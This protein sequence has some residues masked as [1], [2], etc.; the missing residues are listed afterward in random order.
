MAALRDA[1]LG[2]DEQLTAGGFGERDDGV[3]M[4]VCATSQS[5]A[6]RAD[7][8]RSVLA[9]RNSANP[10][11][12]S[13]SPAATCTTGATA[14][15]T[16]Y[17]SERSPPARPCAFVA[18]RSRAWLF[19]GRQ[20]GAKRRVLRDDVLVGSQLRLRA[21]H[22]RDLADRFRVLQIRVNRRND[23]ARFDRDQ[24]DADQRDPDPRVD[25][26]A[27][28]QDAIENV[29]ETC[30]ACRSFNCHSLLLLSGARCRYR[31]RRVGARGR[32]GLHLPLELLHLRLQL[33]G[34]DLPRRW[35]PGDRSRSYRH[36][37]RPISCALSSE[38]TSSRI[39]MVR[40]STSASDTLM[41]PAIT[42]PLSSTRSST[43]TSPVERWWAGSSS[44]MPTDYNLQLHSQQLQGG[45]TR[46]NGAPSRTRRWPR[47]A[48]RSCCPC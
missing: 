34:P 14:A 13:S 17:P 25:D 32:Q 45:T 8:C 38:H 43:S 9:S 18:G 6:R 28:V 4:L 20:L 29:D 48:P 16:R 11:F 44:A 7:A 33:L 15:C 35:R 36:Q 10:S 37:S 39:R 3:R 41:S 47:P 22:R 42:S 26:D 2:E 23:D 1:V 40:S 21:R 46:L 12:A 24:V 27:L 31:L 30:P 19:D 5:T